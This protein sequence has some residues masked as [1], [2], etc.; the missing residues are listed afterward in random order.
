VNIFELNPSMDV[1]IEKFSGIGG[2]LRCGI[3]SEIC[4]INNFYR[5]PEKVVNYINSRKI[6]LHK[7]EEDEFYNITNNSHF[8]DDRRLDEDN[9]DVNIV[10]DF[11]YDLTGCLPAPYGCGSTYEGKITTNKNKFLHKKYNDY[12]NNYWY[13]HNDPG[14]NAIVYL[15]EETTAGTNIYAPQLIYPMGDL[16][17]S[18]PWK[19]KHFWP[20]AKTIT[21]RYNTMVIFD[22]HRFY[23]SMSVND[24]LWFKKYRLN[25][26]Y[27]LE[28]KEDTY[29]SF[30]F[31]TTTVRICG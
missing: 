25:Q 5:Y 24:E 22:G 26:V 30:T 28:P 23:H 4:T 17:H 20:L 27:F 11:L 16:E 14:I 6:P 3:E 1:S 15:N 13:P 21:A 18:S 10:Y 9:S 8:F 19:P 12:E 31:C 7:T 2:H 29:G